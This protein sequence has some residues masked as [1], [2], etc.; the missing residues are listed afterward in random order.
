MTKGMNSVTR[1]SWA[2]GDRLPGGHEIFGVKEGGMGL[3]YLVY[4]PEVGLPFAVKTFREEFLMNHVAVERFRQEARTW[5]Q[6]GQH[7]Q[8]VQA[9]FVETIDDKPHLFLEY[10]EGS[11][12]RDKLCDG[13]MK[14]RT[15]MDL[16]LQICRGMT[17]VHSTAQ[18]VH[19]DLKPSNIMLTTEGCAKITDFGLVKVLRQAKQGATNISTETGVGVGDALVTRGSVG[20]PEYMAPEQWSARAEVDSRAD[21]YGFGV[22]FYEMLAGRRPFEREEGEPAYVL[23]AKHINELPPDPRKYSPEIPDGLSEVALRCLRKKP[24]ERYP[25]FADI[26]AD[27]SGVY[28]KAFSATWVPKEYPL[29]PQAKCSRSMQLAMK[30]VSLQCLEDHSAAISV[31]DQSLALEPNNS[32]AL[33][34]KA[35][36]CCAMANHADAIGYFKQVEALAPDDAQIQ[37]DMAFCLNEMGESLEALR[38]AERSI[39]FDPNG[40][41]SRNNRAIALANLGRVREAQESFEEAITLNPRSAETWNN[42][43]FLLVKMGRPKQAAD[44]FRQAIELN[45]RYLK[46]YFNLKQ[47]ILQHGLNSGQAGPMTACV[48]EAVSLMEAV[49]AVEPNHPGALKVRLTLTRAVGQ[50]GG[51]K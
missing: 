25:S 2:K 32:F 47:L 12:L 20:T 38:H 4:Q 49:L 13:R 23:H 3:V 43:G 41:S 48:R 45:P 17:H 44:C 26:E 27:V 28:E 36:S 9:L 51:E 21:V 10:V 33:R 29:P 8:I 24:A 37:D 18:A 6:L 11:T 50:T 1:R 7:Q 15:A 19:R 22:I 16:A 39:H 34:I 31:L 42:K 46:P 35:R 30:G 14:P 40:S 5:M